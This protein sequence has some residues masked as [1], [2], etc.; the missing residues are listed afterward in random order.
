[1][2][3]LNL[4]GILGL[5]FI[6]KLKTNVK[7]SLFLTIIVLG[8]F[9]SSWNNMVKLWCFYCVFKTENVKLSPRSTSALFQRVSFWTEAIL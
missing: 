6:S 5:A 2:L 9:G 4:I 7:M 1:M 8:Y 3:E